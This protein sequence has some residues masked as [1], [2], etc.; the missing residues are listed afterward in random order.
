MWPLPV[1]FCHLFRKILFTELFY[2]LVNALAVEFVFCKKSDCRAGLSEDVLYTDFLHWNRAFLCQCIAD[3]ASKSSDHGVFF[4]GYDF[5]GLFCCCN[6]QLLIQRFD[7][8]DVDDLGINAVCCKFLCCFQSVAYAKACCND[9]DI[10]AFTEN[11]AFSELKFVIRL[12][13][14]T[15]TARRP[16]RR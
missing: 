14:I 7:G 12:S 15:G 2:L 5:A 11:N 10:L 4:Y 1:F 8:V 3:C 16:K 13:L 6:D 9:G